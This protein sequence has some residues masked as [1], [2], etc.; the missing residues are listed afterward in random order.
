M[1]IKTID[2]LTINQLDRFMSFCMAYLY[3]HVQYFTMKE[4]RALI[5]MYAK[6]TSK[7]WVFKHRRTK[8]PR[9]QEAETISFY[10]MKDGTTRKVT[11]REI[12][13]R[14]KTHV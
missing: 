4:Y 12:N 2:D 9:L 8:N 13:K 1:E 3:N 11:R 10:F 14:C 5:R 6:P 7:G